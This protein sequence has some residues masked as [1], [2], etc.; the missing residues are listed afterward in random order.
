MTIEI[1]KSWGDSS[2]RRDR[3]LGM[4]AAMTRVPVGYSRLFRLFITHSTPDSACS[5]LRE[6]FVPPACPQNRSLRLLHSILSAEP[7]L[8]RAVMKVISHE[9]H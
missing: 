4:T 7:I 3:Y 2:S 9:C 1:R 5:D 8:G 6:R